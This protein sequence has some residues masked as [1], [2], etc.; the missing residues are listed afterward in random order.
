[1]APQGSGSKGWLIALIVGLVVIVGAALVF[2]LFLRSGDEEEIR[3]AIQTIAS[4]PT[5]P[6]SCA[7]VTQRFKEEQ[8]GLTGT[9]AD[10]ACRTQTEA[11]G[12]LPEDVEVENIEID[13]DNATAEVT[14]EGGDTATVRMVNEDGVWLVDGTEE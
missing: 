11:S 2:F 14:G 7:L 5:D 10:E 6:D 3:E 8:S 1:M 12:G 9:A 13:G 4:N